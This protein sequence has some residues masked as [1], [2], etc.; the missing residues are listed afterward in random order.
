MSKYY[1]SND[2]YNEIKNTMDFLNNVTP[3]KREMFRGQTGG[4][5]QL[6][7]KSYTRG[8]PYITFHDGKSDINIKI[9]DLEPDNMMGGDNVSD[10][11]DLSIF[12]SA[13]RNNV[14]DTLDLNSA[15]EILRGGA[16]RSKDLDATSSVF[17]SVIMGGSRKQL[18]FSPTSNDNSQRNT[19]A[20]TSISSI[21]NMKGGDYSATSNIGSMT[22]NNNYS[23]T[24]VSN[25][26]GGNDNVST[27]ISEIFKKHKAQKGGAKKYKDWK[28][29]MNDMGINS[30]SSNIC[31]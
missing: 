30:S 17:A 21:S 25:M 14:E 27:S 3:V 12:K 28:H 4:A 31:E 16:T 6:Q 9:S 1:L 19:Y 7:F 23:E 20:E 2:Q 5:S 24:S 26:K 8:N 11:L 29:K 13:T 18:E 15:I 22:I 10:T